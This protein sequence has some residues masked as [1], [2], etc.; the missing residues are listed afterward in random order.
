[1][2]GANM[3]NKIHYDDNRTLTI[4]T[5]SYNVNWYLGPDIANILGY[6]NIAQAING[7]CKNKIYAN[8]LIDRVTSSEIRSKLLNFHTRTKFIPLEDV[9]NLTNKCT[10]LNADEIN[11]FKNWLN[12]VVNVEIAKESVPSILDQ[13]V[14]ASQLLDAT[15]ALNN[16]TSLFTATTNQINDL[17]KSIQ[18]LKDKVIVL[19]QASDTYQKEAEA[20]AEEAK[21]NKKQAE[22]NAEEAKLNGEKAIKFATVVEEFA[23]KVEIFNQIAARDDVFTMEEAAKIISNKFSHLPQGNVIGRN[24]LLKVLRMENNV[25]I[26]NIASQRMIESGYFVL[27]YT[28]FRGKLHPSSSL[29]T[30]KGIGYLIKLCKKY[31]YLP[32]VLYP[33]IE[34]AYDWAAMLKAAQPQSSTTV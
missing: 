11:K 1:M 24:T 14:P 5:D 7:H 32:V 23:P 8:D 25:S 9:V 26:K 10:K 27:K 16:A 18:I 30:F 22:A 28:E 4:L 29:V 33:D 31:R 2:L 19:E 6:V 3:L 34:D 13:L 15:T 20:N 21:L 17:V 12:N